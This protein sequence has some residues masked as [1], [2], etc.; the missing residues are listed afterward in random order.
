VTNSQ[1]RVGMTWCL[2]CGKHPV[3]IGLAILD[4][5]ARNSHQRCRS[6]T[7]HNLYLTFLA[8]V[9]PFVTAFLGRAHLLA[10]MPT[11]TFHYLCTRIKLLGS[12]HA[13]TYFIIFIYL[14]C[15]S[16]GK[17]QKNFGRGPAYHAV[18]RYPWGRRCCR[19]ALVLQK[20]NARAL[21]W[22][23][24]L[25]PV[26]ITLLVVGLV[27]LVAF[28][29]V[30]VGTRTCCRRRVLRWPRSRNAPACRWVFLLVPL[31]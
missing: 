25:S 11:N 17:Y 10:L 29:V 28:V 9:K 4:E 21:L 6:I 18:L 15:L 16:G 20:K 13:F 23:L 7:L 31:S 27:E 12:S 1:T 22:P 8:R 26:A 24:V 2:V 14:I 5:N 30:A 3:S 19:G